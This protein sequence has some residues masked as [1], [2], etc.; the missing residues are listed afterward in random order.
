[1]L[2]LALGHPELDVTYVT[3]ESQSGSPVEMAYP[4]LAG[5]LGLTFSAFD[6]DEA[7]RV[8]DA[9][10]LSRPDGEAMQ[11]AGRLIHADRPVVDVSGD[12][13]VQDRETYERWYRR[14]HAAPDLLGSAVYGLPEIHPEVRGARLVANPGCYATAALLALAPLVQR[15]MLRLDGL[16]IDGKSGISGAGGRAALA[17]EYSFPAISDNVRGY[18]LVGHRHTA[19]IEQELEGLCPGGKAVVTFAPHVVPM[20]RGLYTTCY[21]PLVRGDAGDIE[22]L[23]RDFYEPAPFVR[24]LSEPPESKQALGTNMCLVHAT[25]DSR[26]GRAI[27]TAALDNLL[28]GAAGQAVQNLNLM[29]G[30]AETSGLESPALW[31]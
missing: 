3:S 30:L 17:E 27:C 1:M 11:L 6:A 4:T 8:S 28:K 13:R 10:I 20:T 14:P 19:E 26:T 29:C 23:Y 12:F 2:R 25:V 31:P 5:R 21:A 22:A 18:S 15:E 9:F 7:L 24:V 16:I